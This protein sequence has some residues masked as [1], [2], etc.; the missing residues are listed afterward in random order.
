MTRRHGRTTS[1]QGR[2]RAAR[3]TWGRERGE[4]SGEET[5]TCVGMIGKMNKGGFLGGGAYRWAPPGDGGSWA[6]APACSAQWAWA[7][8]LRGEGER[9]GHAPAGRLKVGWAARGGG[10]A[11]PRG[12]RLG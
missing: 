6:T 12:D 8:R 11:R 9:L 3:A 1:G 2:L 7:S 4:P 10:S 5:G